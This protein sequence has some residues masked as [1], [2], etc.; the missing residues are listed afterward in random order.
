[1]AKKIKVNVFDDLRAA[2]GD[3][4]AYERGHRVHLRVSE[5]PSPPHSISPKEI[6]KI[7][8]SLRVSQRI[9]ARILNVS[10]NTVESWEQGV[11]R[12]QQAALKLLDI[13]RTSPHILFSSASDRPRRKR[14]ASRRAA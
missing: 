7:R 1:M 13:A 4:I 3:A 9:F 11:R 2:L 6:R 8:R 12:P 14:Q 10:P 5:L